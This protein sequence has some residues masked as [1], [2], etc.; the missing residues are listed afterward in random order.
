MHRRN[1][2][3]TAALSALVGA[4]LPGAA[5]AQGQPMVVEGVRFEG[6]LRVAGSDLLLNGVGVRAVAWLKG[7]AA[8]LYVARPAH[9]M[10]TLVAQPGPK[11]LRLAMLHDAPSVEFTKALDKGVR[12]NTAEA[13]LAA[14]LPALE[15]LKG[16]ILAV[17]AVKQGD[18]VDLDYDP[19]AGLQFIYNGKLRGPALANGELYAALLRS[20][21]G[22]R[23]YAKDLRAGLLGLPG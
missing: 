19:A 11:R 9:D 4:V 7:Y 2:L 6:R 5:R 21:I 13:E 20:F 16:Q 15:A 3:W 8:A 22:E 18:V 14:L 10:P 23:P 17:N 12:R 1:F